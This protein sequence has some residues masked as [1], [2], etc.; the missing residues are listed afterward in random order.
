MRWNNVRPKTDE[1]R[2]ATKFLWFPKEINREIRWLEKATYK[3]VYCGA[4][5]GWHDLWWINK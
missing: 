5:I 3:Q 4:A 1:T 2:E